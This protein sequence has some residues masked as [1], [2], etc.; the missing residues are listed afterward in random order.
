MWEASFFVPVACL[1]LVA[2]FT[3]WLNVGG[4]LSCTSCV[5]ALRCLFHRVAECGRHPFMYQLRAGAWLLVLGVAECERHPFMYQLR[6]GAWLLVLRG[7]RMGDPQKDPRKAPRCTQGA[8]EKSQGYTR[9][10]QACEV[11]QSN[12][13]SCTSCELVLGAHI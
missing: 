6:A 3:G 1:R 8:P 7:G 4:I 5:P 11:P 13:L 10:P 12:P 2:C 9:S